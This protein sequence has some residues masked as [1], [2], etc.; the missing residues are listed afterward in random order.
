M[1]IDDEFPN[2][3]DAIRTYGVHA[4]D[5]G[6]AELR[7][8]IDREIMRTSERVFGG[9]RMAVGAHGFEAQ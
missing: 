7:A 3:G 4:R 8:L 2:L 9:R 1:D 5:V 6:S